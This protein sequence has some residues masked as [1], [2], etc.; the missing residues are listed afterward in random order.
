MCGISGIL[1]KNNKPVS[2]EI[3]QKMNRTL[4]HRGPD[5]EGYF[6]KGP[7]GLAQRRLAIIDLSSGGH[8]PMTSPDGRFT[9]TF[10][11]EIY[12]F[13]ELKAEL[14][15]KGIIFSTRSDTEV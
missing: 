13:I 6:V 7:V 14:E 8:Q 1:H 12:N 15:K 11:G 9:I 2:L 5:D 3:L 10:N 4:A